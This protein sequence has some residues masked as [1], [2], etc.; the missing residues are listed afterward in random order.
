MS[1]F[2][3]SGSVSNSEPTS[4]SSTPV[5]RLDDLDDSPILTLTSVNRHAEDITLPTT[6]PTS[7]PDSPHDKPLSHAESEIYTPATE[8]DVGL[9]D[10]LAFD[11]DL[12][13]NGVTMS[14]VEPYSRSPSSSSSVSQSSESSDSISSSDE[15]EK[16]LS[17]TNS[18]WATLGESSHVD[19]EKDD[20]E[21]PGS[22]STI[23]TILPTRPLISPADKGKAPERPGILR[24]EEPGHRR[25]RSN[26]EKP[27][28]S[29]RVVRRKIYEDGISR[30]FLLIVALCIGLA[31]AGILI[32]RAV[33]ISLLGPRL[34]GLDFD[35]I[36]S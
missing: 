28:S 30:D 12:D 16:V 7:L 36:L 20:M 35:D 17:A 24:T 8:H 1:F 6:L 2:F 10:T 13:T 34:G 5:Q 18:Q 11:F 23:T 27:R 21:L 29:R 33:V 32:V 22:P 4:L 19:R 25:R 26:E 31:S 3:T 9:E 14:R 15:D